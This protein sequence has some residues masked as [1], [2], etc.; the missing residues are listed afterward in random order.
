MKGFAGFER[1][2]VELV[3]RYI[4]N[5]DEISTMRLVSRVWSDGTNARLKWLKEMCTLIPGVT[6]FDNLKGPEVLQACVTKPGFMDA[7]MRV[8]FKRDVTC[9]LV[10]DFIFKVREKHTI[11]G[12][13]KFYHSS[14]R[15]RDHQMSYRTFVRLYYRM[16]KHD[17]LNVS[18]L[19]KI[20]V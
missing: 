1:H 11:V 13:V 8:Y 9:Y 16:F 4:C 3:S 17:I 6:V 2:F 12:A 14:V 7:I 15:I 19:K 18:Y 20:K 10:R 5:V